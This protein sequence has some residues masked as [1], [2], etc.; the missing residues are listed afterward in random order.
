MKVIHNEPEEFITEMETDASQIERGIVRVCYER[1]PSANGRDDVGDTGGHLRPRLRGPH[2]TPHPHASRAAPELG[3]N[4][5]A[6]ERRTRPARPGARRSR[7]AAAGRSGDRIRPDRT[8]GPLH[9]KGVALMLCPRCHAERTMRRAVDW[10]GLY[11]YCLSCG[12]H[13]Y[14]STARTSTG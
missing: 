14:P 5:A 2:R 9:G 7:R 3:R 8:H 12:H 11:R 1:R 13:D 10:F 6:G 4:L